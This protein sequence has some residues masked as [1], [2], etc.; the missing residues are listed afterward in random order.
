MVHLAHATAP[1]V[2]DPHQIEDAIADIR[3]RPG[4]EI[5]AGGGVEH[6]RQ[7]FRELTVRQPAYPER[8]KKGR[9]QLVSADVMMPFPQHSMAMPKV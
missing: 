2:E 3:N 7:D 9:N 1:D 4:G 8:I 5:E 6:A